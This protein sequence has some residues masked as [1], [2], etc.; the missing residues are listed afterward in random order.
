VGITGP[1]IMSYL[2]VYCSL[3]GVDL[4]CMVKGA[5]HTWGWYTGVQD[6]AASGEH[7]EMNFD[8]TPL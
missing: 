1:L 6:K 3:S 5:G 8:S 4:G 7:S 2:Q